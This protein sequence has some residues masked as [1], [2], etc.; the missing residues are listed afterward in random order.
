M[1]QH[2]HTSHIHVLTVEHY[3]K[4]RT[5][6]KALLCDIVL[7]VLNYEQADLSS[8]SHSETIAAD[9]TVAHGVEE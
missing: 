3:H 2:T 6:T 7:P 4:E 1:T 5:I 8:R 9:V